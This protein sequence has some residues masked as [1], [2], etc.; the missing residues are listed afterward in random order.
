MYFIII[1]KLN[2]INLALNI[3]TDKFRDMGKSCSKHIYM[4][5]PAPLVSRPPPATSDSAS[6]QYVDDI[7]L[8]GVV[9][10]NPKI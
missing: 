7:I 4:N 1:A 9:N 5:P 10:K 3:W 6:G 8:A 2:S